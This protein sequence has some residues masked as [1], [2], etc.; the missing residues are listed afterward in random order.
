MSVIENAIAYAE[1]I[2][3]DDSHGYDQ[4]NRWL[5]PDCDCSSYVISCFENGSGLK[6]REAGASYTGNMR[7]AFVKCGFECL[8]YKRGM[9][10]IRG[11]VLLNEQHHTALYIGDGKIAQASINEKGKITGGQKGDQTGKEVAIG[12]FYEYGKGWQ[13]VLRYKEEA[14]TTM[15][16]MPIIKQGSMCNEVG[17][18]QTLLKELGFKAKNGKDLTIDHDFGA[19]TDFAVRLFQRTV[20]LTPDG[21]VGQKTWAC[22]LKSNY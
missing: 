21:I 16:E 9:T 19:N 6:L 3:K 2:A 5:N 13:Y 11:D 18:L 4:I 20:D 15:I 17:T 7:K 12:A 22:L 10:L 1:R 14:K 8:T